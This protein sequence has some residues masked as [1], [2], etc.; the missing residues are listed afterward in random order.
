MRFGTYFIF[1]ACALSLI[2]P[3]SA[4]AQD[5][6]C[7]TQAECIERRQLDLPINT[8]DAAEG[9]VQNDTSSRACGGTTKANPDGNGTVEIGFCLPAGKTK[10]QIA[11]GGRNEFETLA[12]FIK[13]FYEYGFG[14]ASIIAVLVIIVAGLQWATSAGNTSTI[15]A[16]KKR[17]GGAII[18]LTLLGL[19]YTILNFINPRTLELRLP[20]VWMLNPAELA[21]EYCQESDDNLNLAFFATQDE[22]DTLTSKQS[23]DRLQA[24]NGKF[25]SQLKKQAKCGSVYFVEGGGVDRTCNGNYCAQQFGKNHVCGAKKNEL[26]KDDCHPGDMIITTFSSGNAPGWEYPWI[27]EILGINPSVGFEGICSNG[28]SFSVPIRYSIL[29]SDVGNKRQHI[30][31]TFRNFIGIEN[32]VQ[33]ECGGT[34]EDKF[35]GFAFILLINENLDP[36]DETHFI[37]RD[38]K[39]L[40]DKGA[41][42]KTKKRSQMNPY[43]FSL[44]EIKNRSISGQRIDIHTI[45]DIDD[46]DQLEAF[47]DQARYKYYQDL[48][49]PKPLFCA[50]NIKGNFCITPD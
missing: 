1:F 8:T 37:G 25:S 31:L 12:D 14:I 30:A 15:Q 35:K 50:T 11:F 36:I 43:L 40:G 34:G 41:F 45:H 32:L 26:F 28:D 29:D 17:I 49:F 24:A 42:E 10:T 22:V 19:S 33:Q 23:E 3:Q 2:L 39:D 21:P 6:R 38:G 7:F 20:E 27:N 47:G 9:F 13:F 16:A 4:L 5:G 18:G 46:N 44:E 48:G